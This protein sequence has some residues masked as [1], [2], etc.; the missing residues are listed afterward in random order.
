MDWLIDRFIILFPSPFQPSVWLEVDYDGSE[1]NQ[2]SRPV[3]EA[4]QKFR[5]MSFVDLLE[6]QFS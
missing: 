5:W 3:G 6:K 4:H 1:F 2:T